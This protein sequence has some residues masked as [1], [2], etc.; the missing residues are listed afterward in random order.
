MKRI[1]VFLFS[2]SAFLLLGAG[3]SSSPAY[4]PTPS[5]P[6]T[7]N[8]TP[9]TN[10]GVSPTPNQVVCTQD[11]KQCPD[12]SYVS[13]IPPNCDFAACPSVPATPPPPINQP[14]AT[15]NPAPLPTK[16]SVSISNFSFNPATLTVKKG[17]RVTWT[18]NDSVGHTVTADNGSGPGSGLLNNGDS[19][20]YTFDAT[21]TYPYHCSV[22]PSMKGTVIVTQ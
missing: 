9:T 20:N 18:N 4:N 15:N 12:G 14:P 10:N 5:S 1:F 6:V 3:C 7:N 11:A 17:T 13:R 16:A 22:H 19:Y 2:V 8:Q 21:G